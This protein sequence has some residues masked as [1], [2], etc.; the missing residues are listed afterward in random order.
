MTTPLIFESSTVTCRKCKGTGEWLDDPYPKDPARECLACDGAGE[1]PAWRPPTKEEKQIQD[2]ADFDR[3]TRPEAQAPPLA[4]RTTYTVPPWSGVPY[5]LPWPVWS[6]DPAPP[7][8]SL[9]AFER[10]ARRLWA[11]DRAARIRA[12]ACPVCAERLC[13]RVGPSNFV[14]AAWKRFDLVCV[15]GIYPVAPRSDVASTSASIHG[16]G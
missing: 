11:R 14:T 10:D 2:A 15:P 3:R 4:A 9:A 1:V 7:P 13:P 8:Q 6:I 16:M 12:G 5:P